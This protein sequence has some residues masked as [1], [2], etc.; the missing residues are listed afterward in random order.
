MKGRATR[1]RLAAVVM[2]V[3]IGLAMATTACGSDAPAADPADAIPVDAAGFPT[4]WPIAIPPGT[5]TDCDDGSVSQE[6]SLFSVVVCLPDAPDPFTVSQ[7][8]LATLEGE[9]FVEREPGAFLVNQE[10]FLDGNGIEV[11]YQLVED[12][13]TIVLIRPA[14]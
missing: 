12:E 9:G 7:N 6:D 1:H 10:T 3:V 11:Y 8:Y 13:A 14:G 5:I 4:E 2:T